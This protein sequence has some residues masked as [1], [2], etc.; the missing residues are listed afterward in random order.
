M[1][2]HVFDRPHQAGCAFAGYIETCTEPTTQ[3]SHSVH[4]HVTQMTMPKSG[5]SPGP[6]TLPG[7]CVFARARGQRVWRCERRELRQRHHA[8]S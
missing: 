7:S 3:H 2:M 6:E 5:C 1:H 8:R 4:L